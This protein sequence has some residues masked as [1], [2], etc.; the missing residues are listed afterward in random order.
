MA[1]PRPPLGGLS[2]RAFLR[3]YWQ[4]RPLLVRQAIPGFAGLLDRRAL[5]A[6]AANDEAESRLVEKKAGWKVTT[7]PI[8]PRT[9]SRMPRKDWTLLVNG[10]NLH[11]TAADALLKRFAFAS[12]ARVDDVMASYAADGGGVGPH[13]DSYDVFL[14]QGPGRRR[15]RLMP[16]RPGGFRLVEGA[17]LK[18]IA[19]FRPAEEHLLEA[20]DLLYLPPGWGHEGTAMGG[21]QTYSIGFRAPGGAELS[22][23]FLD[24]LH[25]RGFAEEAYRDPNRVPA[26]HPG[27][28]DA[29]FIDHAKRILD[30][31]RWSRPEVADFLG[32]YL[33]EPKQQVAF[34]PPSRPHARPLFLRKLASAMVRLDPRTRMLAQGSRIYMNGTAF[35]TG[36]RERAPLLQLA[37]RRELEGARLARSPAADL[38]FDWYRQ[39]F[40]ALE[41]NR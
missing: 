18:L 33:S 2:P 23:A 8:A 17:P 34:N 39:G 12:W 28:I 32:R 19:D 29:H 40:L 14:L 25:E 9:L 7:G 37:D 36:G 30:R 6:L 15:W 41:K 11:S 21:C 38:V 10:V 31:I 13:V 5:F 4:K 27:R 16:P 35:T 26:P 1:A 20:G 3:G 22:T 24:F